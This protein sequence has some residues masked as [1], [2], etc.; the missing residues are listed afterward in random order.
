MTDFSIKM[1]DARVIPVH[2][3]VLNVACDYFKVLFDS[4]MKEVHA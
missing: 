3:M 4:G 1:A 2:K